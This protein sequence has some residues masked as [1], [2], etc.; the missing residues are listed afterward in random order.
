MQ[1]NKILKICEYCGL[2]F[3]V[4]KSNNKKRFCSRT[5]RGK[6]ESKKHAECISKKNNCICGICGTEFMVF[7]SRIK[8][9]RGKFCSRKCYYEYLSK[10][11]VGDKNPKWIDKIKKT[12]QWCGNEF[13]IPMSTEIIGSGKFC[14]GKCYGMWRSKNLT[15]KN[16]YSWN[17]KISNE[18]RDERR[19]SPQ[20]IVWRK[21]VFERDNYTCQHCGT[22][23]SGIFNA[24]HIIPFSKDKS[25]RFEISNGITLCKECHKKE[26]ARLRG[27]KKENYDLFIT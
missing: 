1:K 23:K 19:F 16:S 22:K 24:H 26:H 3:C 14:S 9:G 5:C 17:D 18:E 10:I 11:L 2:E 20:Y 15:G 7:E 21:S 13:L 12:C 6:W 8:N 25:L 27:L 4:F